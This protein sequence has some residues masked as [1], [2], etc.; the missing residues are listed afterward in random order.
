VELDPAVMAHLYANA[1]AMDE[2]VAGPSGV[3]YTYPD[4][5]PNLG[6]FANVTNAIMQK[7]S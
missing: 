3:G 5:L 6:Q 4:V 1:T 2:F 7:V